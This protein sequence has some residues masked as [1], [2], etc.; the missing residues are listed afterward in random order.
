M[1][2]VVGVDASSHAEAAAGRAVELAR[3]LSAELHVVHVTHLSS[4]VLG[5]AADYG[6]ALEEVKAAEMEQ[7][8]DRYEKLLGTPDVAI[9]RI[10][11]QGPPA[12]TL[13][14]YAAQV[15]ADLL[16]VGSRGRGEV[17]ALVLG[18]TSHRLLHLADRDV[19]VVRAA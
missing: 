4:V 6:P 13:A 11:L 9:T 14:A 3:R 8:W 2:I 17:A 12:D 1:V 18:S 19:L 7:V 16:V 10:D 5:L 15:E